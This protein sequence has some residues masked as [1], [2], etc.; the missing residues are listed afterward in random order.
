LV[1]AGNFLDF[2]FELCFRRTEKGNQDGNQDRKYLCLSLFGSTGAS[3]FLMKRL[4][5]IEV[6]VVFLA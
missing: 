5:L 3:A 4:S 6:S 2:F 1:A